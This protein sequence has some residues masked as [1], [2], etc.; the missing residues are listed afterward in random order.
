MMEAFVQVVRTVLVSCGNHLLQ[1]S[2]AH[3]FVLYPPKIL[4]LLSMIGH[5]EICKQ[6]RRKLGVDGSRPV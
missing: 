3:C 2:S 4:L 1:E 5:R 6:S